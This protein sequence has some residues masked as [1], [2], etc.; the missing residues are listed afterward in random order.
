MVM[1]RRVLVCLLAAFTLVGAAVL[2]LGG[3]AQAA[4][5]PADPATTA[6]ADGFGGGYQGDYLALGDSVP[7]GYNP[8]LAIPSPAYKYV[9][10]P[11]LA[12]PAL[13]LRVTNLSCPG[14]T[15]GGYL[16]GSPQDDN[17][18]VDF[19]THARLHTSYDGTQ[20]AAA[21]AFLKSHPRTRLVTIMLGAND[22][23]LCQQNEPM[24]CTTEAVTAALNAAAAHLAEAVSAIR[25]AYKG[26]LVAVTYY[27]TN[28]KDAATV[29]AIT[30]L[31]ATLSSVVT[32]AGAGGPVA[33]ADGFTPFEQAS[34]PAGDPCAA[35]LLIPLPL[36]TGGCDKH[37]S[38]RGARLLAGAVIRAAYAARQVAA[39]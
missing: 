3:A 19:R 31:N 9:G 14:Q 8:L 23:L 33:I 15:T 5:S 17:G 12:A 10:Y 6:T 36:P 22:L 21:V 18:C 2:P 26:P 38:P 25:N 7:F 13:H 32:A 4:T 34:G 29:G 24:H 16:S 1:L 30:G 11:E 37:P 28:F 20:A 35:G 27:A 39:A